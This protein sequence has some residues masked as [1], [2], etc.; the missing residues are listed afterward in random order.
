MKGD[1]QGGLRFNWSI[2]DRWTDRRGRPLPWEISLLPSHLPHCATPAE[3]LRP[4]P[5][6]TD[7]LL[8][9]LAS[10]DTRLG[11]EVAVAPWVDRGLLPTIPLIPLKSPVRGELSS[12][13]TEQEM[14]HSG[15]PRLRAPHPVPKSETTL[16]ACTADTRAQPLPTPPRPRWAWGAEIVGEMLP[17]AQLI[18]PGVRSA[19]GGPMEEVS[20]RET[21][22]RGEESSLP[23]LE[24]GVDNMYVLNRETLPWMWEAAGAWFRD[25]MYNNSSI[26]ND[27]SLLSACS[28]QAP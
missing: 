13:I 17:R 19:L 27:D 5:S 15:C 11:K 8:Y 18:G 26:R 16:A 9:C 12:P 14:T 1:L 4:A 28:Y 23:M 10:G 24:A 3:C 2:T 20:L 6:P 21:L 7:S 22:A 25:Q